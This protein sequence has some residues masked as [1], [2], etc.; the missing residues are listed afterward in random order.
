M[1]PAVALLL[2]ACATTNVHIGKSIDPKGKTVFLAERSIVISPLVKDALRKHGWTVKH[3]DD[4]PY[5]LTALVTNE[6]DYV[7]IGG[8]YALTYEFTLSERSSGD[9][10]L[11]AYGQHLCGADAIVARFDQALTTAESKQ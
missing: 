7:C 3:T 6:P 10:V 9:E 5:I 8:T 11:N 4:T 1:A 2:C